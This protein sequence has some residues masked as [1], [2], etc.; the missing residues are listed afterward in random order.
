MLLDPKDPT[1]EADE[2]DGYIP[3]E[4]EGGEDDPEIFPLMA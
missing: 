2:E 4:W 3:D 1:E